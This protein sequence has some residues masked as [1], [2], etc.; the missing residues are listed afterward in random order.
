MLHDVRVREDGDPVVLCALGSLDAVH[1]EAAGQAGHT[2]ETAL[3][4]LG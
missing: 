3:E 2:A 1:A 4:A